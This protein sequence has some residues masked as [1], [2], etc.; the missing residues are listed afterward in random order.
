MSEQ[1]YRA[2]E[3]RF[4]ASREEI[5]ARLEN[6]RPFL[7]ALGR[8]SERPR[9]FDIGCGRGEWLQLLGESGMDAQ[10]VDLD[11]SMLQACHERGLNARNQ[12]ALSALKALPDGSLDLITSFHVV[13]HLKFDYLQALLAEAFRTLSPHGLLIL[14]TPNPENLIVG[15]NNFYLDPTH[16]RPVPAI[17]L[18]FLCQHSGFAE[19]RIVRLQEDPA[20]HAEQASIGVWQVLYGVSPDYAIVARKSAPPSTEADPYGDLLSKPYGIDL[21]TLAQRHDEQALQRW[22]QAHAWQQQVQHAQQSAQQWQQHIDALLRSNDTRVAQ[23]EARFDAQH[24]AFQRLARHYEHTREK[25]EVL[26]QDLYLIKTSLVWRA[27]QSVSHML[28]IARHVRSM[29]PKLIVAK[30]I[31]RPV[32]GGLKALQ[33]HPR[34]ASALNRAVRLVPPL[35]A[36]LRRIGKVLQ[37]LSVKTLPP[38]LSIYS[39]RVLRLEQHLEA[40]LQQSP[41]A[42]PPRDASGL[43]RLAYVSPMPPMRTGIADYSAELLPALARYYRIDVIVDDT[44]SPLPASAGAAFQFKGA[45]WLREHAGSYDAVL[46]HFGNSGFHCYMLDL[47]EAVPGIVVLHDF[48]LSGLIWERDQLTGHTGSKLRELHNSHGYTGLVDALQGDRLLTQ[49]YPLNRGVLQRAQGVIVHSAVSLRLAEQ[50]Y[51]PESCA[52]WVQIPLLRELA[53]EQP[54]TAREAARAALGLASD[55]FVVCSFGLLGE[56]KLND[57]L[58]QAWVDSSLAHDS[59]CQLVFVGDLGNDAYGQALRARLAELGNDARVTITG[60]ADADTFARYLAAADVAV[61]LRSLS[62]G[63]TSAA[64]LDCMNHRLPT[65]VNANGSMADL[66][67]GSVLRLPDAFTDA[68]LSAALQTLRNDPAARAALAQRARGVIEEQHTPEHCAGLYHAAIEQFAGQQRAQDRELHDALLQLP[69]VP[70]ERVAMAALADDLLQGQP[71]PLQPRQLLLDITETARTDRHT[72]VERVARALTLAMLRNPPAGYRVEPVYLDISGGQWRYRY[73]TQYTARLLGVPAVIHDLGIDYG[74]GDQLVTLDISGQALIDAAKQGLFSR[75]NASG[76]S[77]ASVVYDLLP[78]TQPDFFPPNAHTF[79]AHWLE[80]VAGMD[81]LLCISATVAGEMRNWMRA[82]QLAHA[83]SLPIS[84]FPLGADLAGSAPTTGEPDDAERLMASFASR[85]TVLM[86]GTLE[87]RKGYL[88]A[89]DAFD[90]LWSRGVDINLVIVGRAGWQQLPVEQQRSIPL[91]LERLRQH[92]KLGQ[93]LFWLDGIS[94]QFLE[95]VYASVDG[96]LAAS[97]DEGYGLPLIESAQKELPVLARDI[98]IFREVAGD[99]AA[100]FTAQ[101]AEQMADAIAQWADAGFLPTSVAMPWSTW[102][103]SA[104]RFR[105][106]LLDDPAPVASVLPEATLG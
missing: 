86:V 95:R 58:L 64:V 50:W 79:F 84:H 21:P 24:D 10:G 29:P 39:P 76:V 42:I 60:W 12:D 75:L 30:T 16:E 68:E 11:D 41:D 44:G 82:Q 7:D 26:E 72:G 67:E 38:Q 66:P 70:R 61:Q 2:L 81:R 74:P 4:R 88:A 104:E 18:E 80:A 15:T 97:V 92:P 56:T 59:T 46:Y 63:E 77:C 90:V 105:H 101:T 100:Y 43:P 35:D 103:Q 37:E 27:S 102:E 49:R 19:S 3:E 6:Y 1:F 71:D 14:E 94:D 45:A 99:H 62:R 9:A 23:L 55:A 65:I 33:K 48:F 13:E 54:A 93:Q 57:R 22:Q 28:R 32:M 20:L 98:P 83:D 40:L 25:A 78:V 106:L 69:R 91:L 17:F 34:L 31:R 87:P 96:L 73:A 47:L 85:P 53:D 89:L 5:R 52:Q 51:G 36:R 8:L